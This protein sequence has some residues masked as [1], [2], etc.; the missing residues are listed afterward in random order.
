[1]PK[2]CSFLSNQLINV[3]SSYAAWFPS[4]VITFISH[5]TSVC[6]YTVYSIYTWISPFLQI[7]AMRRE[8]QQKERQLKLAQ[9]Q[10]LP[11]MLY[12][13]FIYCPA[14]HGIVGV[15][16]WPSFFTAMAWRS[17]ML[18]SSVNTSQ[19]F[20]Y[21]TGSHMFVKIVSFYD[22]LHTLLV[23]C[24]WSMYTNQ[25]KYMYYPLFTAH[26][27][28]I[29]PVPT[30][31]LSLKYPSFSL[32]LIVHMGTTRGNM[33]QWNL[34]QQPQMSHPIFEGIPISWLGGVNKGNQLA[35]HE[36][37]KNNVLPS[38]WPPEWRLSAKLY[39]KKGEEQH[40]KWKPYS[41]AKKAALL[42]VKLII[43]RKRHLPG[44]TRCYST[45]R[46]SQN[47]K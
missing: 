42:H 27:I 19:L 33:V 45:Q 37:R 26:W 6:T 8:L 10:V 28:L 23:V 12:C 29:I 32:K 18:A 9:E 38:P 24:T 31:S 2:L 22:S 30:S 3:S 5:M 11:C 40:R 16:I 7:E 36:H 13:S 15:K 44:Y 17:C 34:C 35:S 1:M 43:S 14:R 46:N 20:I 47:G 4:Y 39:M 21:N 41:L 25:R